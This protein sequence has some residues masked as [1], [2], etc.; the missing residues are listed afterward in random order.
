EDDKVA[1][2]V[3]E[4]YAK[5]DAGLKPPAVELLTQRPAWAK[6][7]MKAI[8]AKK[9]TPDVVNATQAARLMGSKD[10]ELT[11]L[12]TKHWGTVRTERNPEREKVVQEM[13]AFLSRTKGDP[14][15]GA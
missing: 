8:A 13:K 10:R 4:R 6:A 1:A 9:L 3:L 11:E 2:V 12:V 15:K 5:L 7:L 14:K